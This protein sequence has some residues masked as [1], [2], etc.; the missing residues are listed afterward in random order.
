MRILT[1]T[2]HAPSTLRPELPKRFDEWMKKALAKR[3]EERFA[4]AAELANTLVEALTRSGTDSAPI[5]LG[6]D[7]IVAIDG[8]GPAS[9]AAYSAPIEPRRR[10]LRMGIV[11]G[12]IGLTVAVTLLVAVIAQNK[13]SPE[14]QRAEPSAASL[15]VASKPKVELAEETPAP[16]PVEIEPV[17]VAPSATA[18]PPTEETAPKAPAARVPAKPVSRPP[19]STAEPST[20]EKQAGELWN[21]KDEL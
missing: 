1:T 5:D 2:P 11:A 7:D 20:I 13:D 9:D 17:I 12:A 16:P 15:P 18:A 10:R 14:P 19:K 3:R 8:P 21:K 6:P 4:S